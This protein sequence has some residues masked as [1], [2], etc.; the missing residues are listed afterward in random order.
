MGTGIG[1]LSVEVWGDGWGG[2]GGRTGGQR[3]HTNLHFSQWF[4]FK[5]LVRTYNGTQGE[6]NAVKK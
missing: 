2:H 4:V 1:N 5:S 6:E 3:K